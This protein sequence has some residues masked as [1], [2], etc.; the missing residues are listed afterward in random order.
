MSQGQI[1]MVGKALPQGRPMASLKALD[2]N[3]KLIIKVK[4]LSSFWLSKS[5]VKVIGM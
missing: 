2:H 3:A 4:V 1:C 5:N